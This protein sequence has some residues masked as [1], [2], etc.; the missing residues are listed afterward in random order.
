MN[1]ANPIERDTLREYVADLHNETYLQRAWVKEE[2]KDGDF[3]F[4]WVI[5]F[6]F[7][8]T[9][10]AEKPEVYIGKSLFNGEEVAA[11]RRMA[12]ALDT[13]LTACEG[14]GL[15]D[16]EYLQRPEWP[17]IHDAAQSLHTLIVSNDAKMAAS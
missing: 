14:L 12:T 13:L 6:F 3:P 17:A 11:V 7:D 16:A 10:Y 9:L 5:D 4:D 15:S 2:I 8:D 1:M